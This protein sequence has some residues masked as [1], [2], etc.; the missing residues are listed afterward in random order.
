MERKLVNGFYEDVVEKTEDEL[1]KEICEQNNFTLITKSLKDVVMFK[2]ASGQ[3]VSILKA[4]LI[5]HTKDVE[6]KE[7]RTWAS[8]LNKYLNT[9]SANLKRELPENIKAQREENRRFWLSLPDDYF[10]PLTDK[11]KEHLKNMGRE[12]FTVDWSLIGQA[13]TNFKLHTIDRSAT[14][15]YTQDVINFNMFNHKDTQTILFTDGDDDYYEDDYID[16]EEDCIDF[17]TED[18]ED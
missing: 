18:E 6:V 1:I 8:I 9:P 7:K 2:D 10:K 4:N 13:Y 16:D 15:N 17:E 5:N 3:M 11:Q 14:F 12:D